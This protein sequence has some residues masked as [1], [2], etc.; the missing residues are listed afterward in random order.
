MADLVFNVGFNLYVGDAGPDNSKHLILK[1]LKVPTLEELTA[2][3]HAGGAFMGIEVGGLGLKPLS[4]SFKSAGWDDQTLS[5]F[6]INGRSSYP[7]TAYGLARTKQGNQPVR[8]KAVTFGRLT[9]VEIPEMK[10]G[11]ILEPDYEIKEILHY[12]LWYSDKPKY[13]FDWAT[14]R[15]EIDG[16]PQNQD[17]LTALA[18]PTGA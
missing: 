4:S 3:H 18:I 2:E 5:Q 14:G 9:K 15:Y 1:G 11:D 13:Y 8:T 12:E 17:E 6:G 10:R 7:F 16:V